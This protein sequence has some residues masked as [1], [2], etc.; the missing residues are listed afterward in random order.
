MPDS[1]HLYGIPYTDIDQVLGTFDV[2]ERRE[3][4]QFGEYRTKL[5]ILAFY[6]EMAEAILTGNPYQT[7]LD[8]SPGPPTDA[9]GNF[10][11]MTEWAPNNWPSHIHPPRNESEVSS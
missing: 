7:R 2:L 11:P 1:F 3:V 6:S 4:H 5:Q 8:P 10:I 9:E